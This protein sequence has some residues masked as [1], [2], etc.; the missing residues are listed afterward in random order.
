MR[1]SRPRTSV[2]PSSVIARRIRL[3]R[4]SWDCF[5]VQVSAG[6]VEFVFSRPEALPTAADAN[7]AGRLGQAI[8]CLSGD[9]VVTEVSSASGVR[10]GGNAIPFVLTGEPNAERV[11]AP[12][13]RPVWRSGGDHLC[14]ANTMAM[15]FMH[16]RPNHLAAGLLRFV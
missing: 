3:D 12:H 13:L 10:L 15:I 4:D 9:R 11:R 6:S 8:W 1:R 14:I 7:T 2:S 16:H 5:C